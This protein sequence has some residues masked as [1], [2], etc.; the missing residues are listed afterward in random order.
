MSQHHLARI[1]VLN[2]FF[3]ACSILRFTDSAYIRPMSHPHSNPM[4]S[5]NNTSVQDSLLDIGLRSIETVTRVVPCPGDPSSLIELFRAFG[6]PL[7][8]RTLADPPHDSQIFF[9]RCPF[10]ISIAVG[11]P[12]PSIRFEIETQTVNPSLREYNNAAEHSIR[13][14]CERFGLDPTV[15]EQIRDILGHEWSIHPSGRISASGEL[16]GKVYI[17]R[18]YRF[19][20]AFVRWREVFTLLG[21]ESAI[22][23]LE[24]V[25]STGFDIGVIAI[26]LLPPGQK[27]GVE[28]YVATGPPRL[29]DQK[30]LEQL[31]EAGAGYVSGDA[32]KFV[33]SLLGSAP[34]WGGVYCPVLVSYL[35]GADSIVTPTFF[36]PFPVKEGDRLLNDLEVSE[37]VNRTLALF[38]LPTEPYT[39][40]LHALADRPLTETS[41]LHYFIGLRHHNGKP[42]M[43]TYFTPPIFGEQVAHSLPVEA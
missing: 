39:A 40:A 19:Q 1:F 24:R 12:S 4:P 42:L 41:S 10:D 13:A 20:H 28:L 23:S 43:A 8:N 11:G 15:F 21:H 29:I 5:G 17:M 38:G 35:I 18:H 9:N 31:G 14:A 30:E 27:P 26:D 16:Y 22:A 34:W 2:T 3:K 7:R 33:E 36:V 6:Q 32:T 25:L 37:R